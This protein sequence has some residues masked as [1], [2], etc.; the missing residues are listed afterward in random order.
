MRE[1]HLVGPR[2]AARRLSDRRLETAFPTTYGSDL[3]DRWIQDL[4]QALRALRKSPG[5]A[6]VAMLSLAL[7]MG[8]NSTI[9]SIA[10]AL[11]LQP[12]DGADAGRLVRLYYGRHSP[13]SWQD[14]ADVTE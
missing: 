8:A 10:S 7:G 14:L 4:R 11:L 9:F 2:R 13:F 3:M 12:V 1:R 5:F 6:L